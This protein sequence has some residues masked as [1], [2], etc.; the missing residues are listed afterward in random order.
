MPFLIIICGIFYL[1][2]LYLILE[3]I[4]FSSYGDSG[5]Q[6]ENEE[7][8]KTLKVRITS[9][10]PVLQH[11]VLILLNIIS[12]QHVLNFDVGISEIEWNLKK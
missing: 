10:T 12:F 11:F 3:N 1:I 7:H 8:G 6:P 2:I 5:V 9:I 4:R